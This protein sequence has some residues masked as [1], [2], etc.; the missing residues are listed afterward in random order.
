MTTFISSSI[1]AAFF[2]AVFKLKHLIS[3]TPGLEIFNHFFIFKID[4]DFAK[5]V[6][7]SIYSINQNYLKGSV[8]E[9]LKGVQA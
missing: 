3:K 9:K 8:R 6:Q 1:H 2:I 4:G 7:I 5:F